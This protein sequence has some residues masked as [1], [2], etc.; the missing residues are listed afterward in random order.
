MLNQ[1][2]KDHERLLDELKG[3]EVSVT[4]TNKKID[5]LGEEENEL[6]EKVCK[7][8]RECDKSKG[9]YQEL[10]QALEA[11]SAKKKDLAGRLKTLDNSVRLSEGELDQSTLKR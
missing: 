7:L 2:Q 1:A 9:E 3:K 11:T 10:C 6:R 4:A 5:L 8:E